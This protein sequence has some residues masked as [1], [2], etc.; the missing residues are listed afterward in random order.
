MLLLDWKTT[1]ATAICAVACSQP[2]LA[3]VGPVTILEVDT[4]NAVEY[5]NDITSQSDPSKIA[6]NP[7]VTPVSGLPTFSRISDLADI[8]A[9]NGQPVKGVLANWETALAASPAPN[10]GPHLRA[11]GQ[12]GLPNGARQGAQERAP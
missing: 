1:L 3:Q 7:G 12:P 5:F 11:V 8:V 4:E 2:G 6:T 9:V 10:P